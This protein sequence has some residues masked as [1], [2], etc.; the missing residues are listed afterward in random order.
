MNNYSNN[1]QSENTPNKMFKI[2]AQVG[3][4]DSLKKVK[5]TLLVREVTIH[6]TL[7]EGMVGLPLDKMQR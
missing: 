6:P 4:T 1:Q 3:K 5:D 7:E 2:V